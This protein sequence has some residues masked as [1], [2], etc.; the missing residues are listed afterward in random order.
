M[1]WLIAG[2]IGCAATSA[3]F[4]QP[5][6]APAAHACTLSLADLAA[7]AALSFADFD[8]QGSTPSTARQ[9]GN[10]KCYEQAARATEHYLVHGPML[11]DYQRNV[12]R[13][14]LGQYLASAG[15]ESAAALVMAATR[16]APDPARPDFDWNSS[17][18]GT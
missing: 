2:L 17:V 13:W 18:V 6:E 5:A 10:R 14:H 3:A 1:K 4:G 15:Q 11:D 8:Q 12:V 9:L 16:R 7:N